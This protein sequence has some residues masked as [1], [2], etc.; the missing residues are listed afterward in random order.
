MKKILSIF[1][2]FTVLLTPLVFA[3]SAIAEY[4]PQDGAGQNISNLD[5]HSHDRF[6][7]DN[8]TGDNN[9]NSGN[10]WSNHQGGP[11]NDNSQNDNNHQGDHRGGGGGGW[12]NPSGSIATNPATNITTTDATLNGTNG[13]TAADGHSFW[14]SLSTFSTASSTIPTGV[15][16][17]PDFGAIAPNTA[18]SALLSSVTTTG[19]PT[20]MPAIT[21]NTTYYFAAWSLVGG[22]WYPGSVLTFTTGAASTVIFTHTQKDLTTWVPYGINAN[23]TY[24]T[25][26]NGKFSATGVPSG[27]TLVYYPDPG[28]GPYTGEVYPVIG[29]NMNLPMAS[30]SVGIANGGAKLWLIPN[31]DV[32][33]TINTDGSQTL[34]WGDASNFLFEKNLMTYIATPITHT[35]KNLTTWVPIL[36]GKN[37]DVV[38][39]T[40]AGKLSATGVPSGYTLVYYPNVGTYDN[41]TGEVYPVV[42]TSMN[43][44]MANDLNGSSS[45][46]YCTS[47]F[48]PGASLCQGAKLWLVPNADI[49]PTINTDGSQTLLGDWNTIA[50]NILF[51]KS[52]MTYTAT[53]PSADV[54]TNPATLVTTTGATVNGTNGPVNADNTSFWWGT[55]PAGSLTAMADPTSEFP[56]GWSRDSGLGSVL[57]GIPFIET[58]TSLTPNTT[59]NFVAW[60]LVG[61]TWYPGNVLTFTTLVTNQGTGGGHSSSGGWYPIIRQMPNNNNYNGGGRVLGVSKAHFTQFMR[62]GSKG[63]LVMELQK[64]LITAGYYSGIADGVFGNTTRTAVIKL[65]LANH[66]RADGIVGVQ[67]LALINS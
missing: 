43:L 47:G 15:Y 42:G 59:Y 19:L 17:T 30:D 33:P 5:N 20:N 4:I 58:L 36:N 10:Q 9:Q 28:S 25:D 32:S 55:G 29:T 11:G 65:Q 63:T 23:V 18:F 62:L 52:L 24:S 27:Y 3:S 12:Q 31:A 41:Y 67:T 14:V 49:S 61:G 6:N 39:S 51:E 38:I 66:I 35:Q 64:Y 40:V 21:P 46:N 22:T 13:A 2:S 34:N 60:S 48:N 26:A 1:I 50:P 37:A 7:Q 44:P 45:S 16:S 53:S 57:A 8:N 54:I 56:S